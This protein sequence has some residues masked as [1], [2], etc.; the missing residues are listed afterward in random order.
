MN[1]S[2]AS[3]SEVK[4]DMVFN[5]KHV[6]SHSLKVKL[7][8]QLAETSQLSLPAHNSQLKERRVIDYS[9]FLNLNVHHSDE[10]NTLYSCDKPGQRHEVLEEC[11]SLSTE[12]TSQGNSPRK[13]D[14]ESPKYDRNQVVKKLCRKIQQEN[15]NKPD[16]NRD[17]GNN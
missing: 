7:N 10:L 14:P 5:A 4:K 2:F 15:S 17:H 12:C 3:Q 1:L 16:T 6:K 13:E 8:E 11:L 9:D